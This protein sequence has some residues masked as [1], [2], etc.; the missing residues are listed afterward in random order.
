MKKLLVFLIFFFLLTVECSVRAPTSPSS[1]FSDEE[2]R[3]KESS[4]FSGNSLILS[5]AGDIMAHDVNYSRP[6]YSK[7]YT[8]LDY[9]L[10][11]DDLTF[12]NLEFPSDPDKAPSN[13]PSF[14][15]PPSYIESAIDGGFNVFSIAN[16][17]VNDQGKSSLLKTLEVMDNLK[18]KRTIYYSGIVKTPKELFAPTIIHRQNFSIAFIAVTDFLNSSVG[19][20]YVNLLPHQNSRALESFYEYL[21]Q[22]DPEFDLIIL[23][24]HIG[25][26][27][28]GR[29][30]EYKKQLFS[31]L[32]ASGADIIWAHHPHVL[33]S[34]KTANVGNSLKLIIYSAGNFVSGQTWNLEPV[35]SSVERGHT[36]VSAINRVVIDKI[37][38]V[39]SIRSVNTFLIA[40]YQTPEGMVVM[41]LETLLKMDLPDVWKNHY[42]KIKEQ[43]YSGVLTD[44]LPK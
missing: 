28:S 29:P 3:Q 7:I 8:Q 14:N 18:K 38:G 17:H 4:L 6:P 2:R 40:N 34:V 11:S 16:N 33:Q 30:G 36:G 25:T 27:Y 21:K 41:P 43:I 1:S 10:R 39:T 23:S 37:G 20:E 44:F 5:F 32:L 26:E 35:K 22:L 31:Q 15:A 42:L 13:Y 19:K 12:G 24:Y 9:L